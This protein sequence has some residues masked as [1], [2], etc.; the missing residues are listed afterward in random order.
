[1]KKE[2]LYSGNSKDLIFDPKSSNLLMSF[3]DRLK[4]CDDRTHYFS[5]KGI[6]CNKISAKLFSLLEL[7]GIES[8]FIKKQN[9]HQ[10][11]VSY[12][13]MFPITIF[14]TNVATG[15]YVNEFTLEEG[16]V[17]H[18]PIIDFRIKN[19]ELKYPAINENQIKN[20]G[21]LTK[22][23]IKHIKRQAYRIN[24]FLVGVF[25]S[26][27]LRLVEIKLEF[28]RDSENED[29][30]IILADELSPDNIKIWDL[31]SNEKL[32]YE[33]ASTCPDKLLESYKLIAKKLG[34]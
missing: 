18:T 5:G 33:L 22:Y 11:M 10:Q 19:S 3:E 12:L 9:M 7:T 32:S 16:V 15:R 26:V 17:F 20:F 2:K 34:A 8:H 24:D 29:Y 25:A 4:T 23:E 30:T 21:W 28:G 6:L 13:E 14:I 1:M 27:G 31:E